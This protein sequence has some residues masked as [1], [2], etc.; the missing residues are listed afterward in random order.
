MLQV[1]VT[2]AIHHLMRIVN[3][4]W[5]SLA[6]AKQLTGSKGMRAVLSP[7]LNRL[8]EIIHRTCSWSN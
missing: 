6:N 7:F 1:S 5:A 2:L 8:I 4:D 3:E